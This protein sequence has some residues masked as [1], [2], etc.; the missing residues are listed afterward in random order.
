MARGAEA[1][2]HLPADILE[3]EDA[4]PERPRTRGD[5]RDGIRPCPW[6]LCRYSLY[7]DLD[8]IT[9]HVRIYHPRLE[10]WEVKGPSCALDVAERGPSTLEEVG[11]IYGVTRERIRQI[12]T[13]A[14]A[15]LGKNAALLAPLAEALEE[16]PQK[17]HG[18]FAGFDVRRVDERQTPSGPVRHIDPAEYIPAPTLKGCGRLHCPPLPVRS[19]LP[20][21]VA[22]NPPEPARI[23]QPNEAQPNP[24]PGPEPAHNP[25][26]TKE[27]PMSLSQ[28]EAR[29]LFLAEWPRYSQLVNGLARAAGLLEPPTT[30][31]AAL[32][33]PAAPPKPRKLVA[34]KRSRGDVN[35]ALYSR[36]WDAVAAS[37][38]QDRATLAL[39]RKGKGT[40]LP[41]AVAC[42]LA[43]MLGEGSIVG[44]A[45][46]LGLG[47]STFDGGCRQVTKLIKE[48]AELAAKVEGLRAT[49][50]KQEAA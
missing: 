19:P 21:V 22:H 41:R 24:G 48:D 44:Q 10:P 30:P 40:Q 28:D 26:I 20:E 46:N 11:D 8:P 35:N 25:L 31:R 27:V 43:S 5:C 7:L 1:V 32:P 45:R 47:R 9:G 42:Y 13:K 14:L 18:D 6:V 34:A 2:T 3:T 17:N 12:E 4:L 23:T 49:L 33:A 29:A 36:I 50:E 37:F 16:A 15:K 39:G 38:G